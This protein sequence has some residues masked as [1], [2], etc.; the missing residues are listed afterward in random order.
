MGGTELALEVRLNPGC[1]SYAEIVKILAE[2][3]NQLEL[4]LRTIESRY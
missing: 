3:R 2:N 4:D 1:I